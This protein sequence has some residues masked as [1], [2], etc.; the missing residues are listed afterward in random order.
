[1]RK[2][3]LLELLCIADIILAWLRIHQCL[4]Y[5]ISPFSRLAKLIVAAK[6]PKI[7][8]FRLVRLF[9]L[10]VLYSIVNMTQ[11]VTDRVFRR[12]VQWTEVDERK[13][14][15]LSS[16]I[17]MRSSYDINYLPARQ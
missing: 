13:V 9:I 12:H 16:G 8:I 10:P 15:N 3:H 1:M 7:E 11:Q 17:E 2:S 5:I 14:F 6:V 4:E